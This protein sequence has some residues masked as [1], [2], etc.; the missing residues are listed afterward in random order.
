MGKFDDN[1][2]K[3]IQ[4]ARAAGIPSVDV[5]L[6]PCRGKPAADQVA[7]TINNLTGSNYTTI[8]LDIETNP[9]TN[10]SWDDFTFE[11]NC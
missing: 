2:V 10:C 9:S 1:A 8:W 6:F 3:S 4:T 7:Q 11:E 5:Y